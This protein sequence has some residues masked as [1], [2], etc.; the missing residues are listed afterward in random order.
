MYEVELVHALGTL[1]LFAGVSE[2]SLWKLVREATRADFAPGETIISAVEYGS[3][4]YVILSGTVEVSSRPVA[5]TLSA[6]DYFGELSLIDGRPRLATAV[7][8][9]DVELIELPQRPVLKL[10]RAHSAFT[11]T[12]F[13][14]LSLRLRRLEATG[15]G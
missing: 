1:P 9:S 8:L 4:L 13:R 11:L 14:D 7:A 2:R 6:G 15:A 10:A 5:R 12:I 3:H